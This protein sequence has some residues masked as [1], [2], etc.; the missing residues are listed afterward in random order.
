MK[1]I[2]IISLVIL[3]K[4]TFS[5]IVTTGWNHKG[6]TTFPVNASG[7]IN[8][9]GR[10]SQLKFH[11]IDSMKMY[12]ASASGGMYYSNDR[13]DSWNLYSG[14]TQIPKTSI[15]S[16]CIDSSNNNIIYMGTGDANYYSNG[17]GVYKSTN[18][19]TTFSAAN[20]GMGNTGV[21]EILQMPGSPSTLIAITRDGIFKSTNAAANWTRRTRSG[22]QMYDL[23]MKPKSNGRVWY[24]CS[25]DSFYRSSD[26]GNTWQ[27]ITS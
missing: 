27:N 13:G 9:I 3:T 22:L 12:A 25:R 10:I 21:L 5:Q 1:K 18:N 7:Q 26:Y 11:P 6:P 16:I 17:Y 20:T 4:A 24:A 15:A 8:G 2:L 23:C 19:G 14:S